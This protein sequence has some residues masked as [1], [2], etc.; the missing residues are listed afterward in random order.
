MLVVR[1]YTSWAFALIF[2]GFCMS[3]DEVRDGI[4]DVAKIGREKFTESVSE[5]IDYALENL[6][7]LEWRS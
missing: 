3:E 4:G 5:G 1:R 6:G 7:E 2:W